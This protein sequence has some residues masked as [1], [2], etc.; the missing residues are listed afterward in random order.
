[1]SIKLVTTDLTALPTAL[2]ASAKIHMRVDWSYDDDFIKSVVARAIGR[3]EQM[4]GVALNAATF[5]WTPASTEFCQDQAEVPV[6]PVTSFVAKLADDT[7]VSSSY[8]I[9]TESVF[10]VPLLHLNGAY[11]N[12]V[13]LT[14]ETG[15]ATLPPPVLDIVMRNA[16]HLYEHREILIPGTEFVAPDMQVDAT[17][18]V[19]RA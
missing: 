6:T 15:F 10:G 5:E 18:W 12:G 2:L 11:Q 4:N 9:T 17:W 3:F 13:V 14:L 8:T 16:A 19:P 1:M 7:D